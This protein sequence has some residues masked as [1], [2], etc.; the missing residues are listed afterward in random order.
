MSPEKQGEE[1][2][3]EEYEEDFEVGASAPWEVQHSRWFQ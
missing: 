1:E 2:G 3:A